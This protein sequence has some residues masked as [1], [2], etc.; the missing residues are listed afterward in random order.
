MNNFRFLTHLE[1]FA[2]VGQCHKMAPKTWSTMQARG[3]G[4]KVPCKRCQLPTRSLPLRC[5]ATP[6]LDNWLEDLPVH[7]RPEF[8]R[9]KSMQVLLKR[10]RTAIMADPVLRS[11]VDPEAPMGRVMVSLLPKQSYISWHQDNGPYHDRHLRFHIALVTNPLCF[12]HSGPEQLHVPVGTLVWF[13][14][15]ASHCATNWGHSDRIH[16][17]FELPRR[18]EQPDD[19]TE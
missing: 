1:T 10:A 17:I 11:I 19:G 5:H 12:L 8:E 4:M 3:E 7:D 14:N 13:N 9:W 18:Q 15:R 6:D 2:V 16:V